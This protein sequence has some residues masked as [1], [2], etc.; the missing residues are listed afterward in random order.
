MA[1][2][3][4]NPRPGWVGGRA[5]A[6]GARAPLRMNARARTRVRASVP[7]RVRIEIPAHA[8]EQI[9]FANAQRAAG[10]VWDEA[11]GAWL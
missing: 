8:Q 1:A 9:D 2:G 11:A 3:P 4:A 7:A 10:L 6:R 5:S